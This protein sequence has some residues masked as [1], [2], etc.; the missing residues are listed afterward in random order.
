MPMAN[1]KIAAPASNNQ[2]FILNDTEKSFEL[3]PVRLCIQLLGNEQFGPVRS[4]RQCILF[5]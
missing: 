1:P 4:V 2:S 3:G 5:S